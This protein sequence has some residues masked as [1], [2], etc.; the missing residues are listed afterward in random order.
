MRKTA[1]TVGLFAA[2]LIPAGLQTTS[3]YAQDNTNQEQV[4]QSS[5]TVT[6]LPGD[7]LSKIAKANESTYQ[8][9]YYANTQVQNPDL[10]YPGDDLRI[11]SADEQL[12]ERPLPTNAPVEAPVAATAPTPKSTVTTKPKAVVNR[13]TPRAAAPAPSVAGGSTWDRLAQCES[14]GRWDVNTGNGYYGGLQF[15]PSSWRAVG[16]SGLPHQASR[17]EQIMRAEKLRAMQGWG[18]WPACSAKLGLR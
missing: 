8:R 15:T 3:A 18:A 11:P 13:A 16:G 12:T 17:E 7:N 14:G 2:A 1:L 4:T 5:V 9:I 10:I 6:V